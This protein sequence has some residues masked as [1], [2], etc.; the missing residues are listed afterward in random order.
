MVGKGYINTHD[1]KVLSSY[2]K[3]NIATK[4]ILIIFIKVGKFLIKYILNNSD[5]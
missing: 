4:I 5:I 2:L 1:D 3:S